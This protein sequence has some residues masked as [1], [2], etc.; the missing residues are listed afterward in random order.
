MPIVMKRFRKYFLK[1]DGSPVPMMEDQGATNNDL[2]GTI[3]LTKNVFKLTLP[4]PAYGNQDF[5]Y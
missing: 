1:Q 5:N 2:L 3:K 4:S